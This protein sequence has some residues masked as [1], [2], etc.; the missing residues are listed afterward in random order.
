MRRYLAS[1][2]GCG[3]TRLASAR[4]WG[5]RAALGMFGARNPKPIRYMCAT[6]P[7]KTRSNRCA[8]F[9][10]ARFAGCKAPRAGGTCALKGR[11]APCNSSCATARS[12]CAVRWNR[13]PITL[14]TL[15]CQ[16]PNMGKMGT[17]SRKAGGFASSAETGALHRGNSP[18]CIG[19]IF[20]WAAGKSCAPAK[21]LILRNGCNITQNCIAGTRNS[22]QYRFGNSALRR[23]GC[24]AAFDPAFGFWFER[25]ASGARSPGL[26]RS[27]A[28]GSAQQSRSFS[29]YFGK[30]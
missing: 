9:G 20:V 1:I 17:T 22:A 8:A 30:R 12:N 19:A 26:P 18:F 28:P 29:R 4:G 23:Y 21:I 14:I 25:Q 5:W 27:V 7:G 15:F 16:L 11:A 6:P 2:G 24:R 13:F 3:S 10:L